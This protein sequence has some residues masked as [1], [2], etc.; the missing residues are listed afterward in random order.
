[1]FINETRD[2]RTARSEAFSYFLSDPDRSVLV[3][4]SLTGWSFLIIF[5]HT[6]SYFV[7]RAL[8]GVNLG[9]RKKYRGAKIDVESNVES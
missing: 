9:L 5:D 1:M 7:M 8:R 2:Q 4:G 3:R 6:V